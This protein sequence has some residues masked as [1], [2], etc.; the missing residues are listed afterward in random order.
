MVIT[1]I[2]INALI[3]VYVFL[4]DPSLINEYALNPDRVTDDPITFITSAFLHA[5]FFHLGMNMLVLFV[6]RHIEKETSSLGFLFIYF[7]SLLGGS[8]A[9]VLIS[10]AD[11]LTVGA[12][13]AVFGILGA[14]L[15]VMK[16]QAKTQVILFLAINIAVTMNSP[17]IS[18]QAHLG[19]LIAGAIAGLFFMSRKDNNDQKTVSRQ[20]E[21]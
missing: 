18:W 10:P 3:G 14:W 11:S 19:G 6:F 13:G 17:D 21:H 8:G 12:S 15:V 20:P 7:V 2:I 1:L 5:D 16:G 9:V 4:V